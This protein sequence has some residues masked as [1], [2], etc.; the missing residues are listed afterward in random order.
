MWAHDAKNGEIGRFGELTRV[1]FRGTPAEA[2]LNVLPLAL[3][4]ISSIGL[5]L[6]SRW[7]L[8]VL[9]GDG[10]TTGH[11]TAK[12]ADLGTWGTQY[13]AYLQMSRRSKY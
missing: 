3:P 8:T 6:L 13:V 1:G 10:H 9:R 11:K 4:L 12:M 7:L 2:S 5:D